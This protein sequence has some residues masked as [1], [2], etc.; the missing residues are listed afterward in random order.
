MGQCAIIPRTI[1]RLEVR[2]VPIM[3]LWIPI[4]VSAIFVFLASFILHMVLPLH[5]ND[6]RKL[7]KED[8]VMAAL[9]GFNIPPG[10][11]AIPC[12]GSPEGMRAPQFKAKL[13]Q[14]PVAFM[15]IA[16]P[17]STSMGKPMALWFVYSIVVSIFAAYITGRALQPGVD[18]LQVFRFAGCTA[19]LGYSMALAQ[20]S[21][22]YSRDWGTTIR[23]MI[24]GLIYGLL[25]A[26]TFGW[27]WPR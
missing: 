15:T 14:G 26:G 2:V 4:L 19:F 9:R 16:P 12:A 7:A 17:R 20:H 24:D 11:Y 22:W 21:I 1:V 8:D 3:S 18:Y 13:A 25:T 10:D 5:R 27:L 6:L 23:S